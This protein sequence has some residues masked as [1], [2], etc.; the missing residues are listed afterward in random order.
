MIDL[1]RGDRQALDSMFVSYNSEFGKLDLDDHTSRA[2]SSA[3]L[4]A[5]DELTLMKSDHI[6]RTIE[7][8]EVRRFLI[9][10]MVFPSGYDANGRESRLDPINQFVATY[11]T[12]DEEDFYAA[13]PKIEFDLTRFDQI[14]GGV[15]VMPSCIF[16]ED[17]T[18]DFDMERKSDNG[19]LDDVV[20]IKGIDFWPED[21][22]G[23]RLMRA[24]QIIRDK[25][26][27][28]I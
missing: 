15:E 12:F 16:D 20:V 22:A 23:S 9:M 4:A 25:S 17:L 3:M 26:T 6:R 2:M 21:D 10:H 1:S 11:L 28:K 13:Y 14:F 8:D 7:D 18:V 27:I 24:R 19:Y 5:I